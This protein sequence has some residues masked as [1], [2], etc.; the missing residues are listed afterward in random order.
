MVEAEL[1]NEEIDEDVDDSIEDE[2]LQVENEI[3][4]EYKQKAVAFWRSRKKRKRRS[5]DSIKTQFKKVPNQ[6]VLYRWEKQ[7]VS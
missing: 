2:Y 5:F 1:I 7:I 4:L 3:D 6:N